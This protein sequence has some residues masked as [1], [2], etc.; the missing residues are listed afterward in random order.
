MLRPAYGLV[1]VAA[2][3]A[4]GPAKEPSAAPPR[5]AAEATGEPPPDY[6]P[7]GVLPE[8]T[9]Y[10]VYP[11]GERKELESALLTRRAAPRPGVLVFSKV[12]LDRFV[13]DVAEAVAQELHVPFDFA[14]T[15]RPAFFD[16]AVESVVVATRVLVDDHDIATATVLPPTE[17]PTTP[18]QRRMTR[19]E[20]AHAGARITVRPDG[21]ARLTELAERRPGYPLVVVYRGWAGGFAEA[22]TDDP[23]FEL[24]FSWLSEEA[25]ENA[26]RDF[27]ARVT[28][29]R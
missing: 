1:L 29:R 25:A 21:R 18:A 6:V 19:R 27:V 17:E 10:D 23:V 4:H 28:K 15:W 7:F 8:I 5:P 14:V 12:P 22:R 13:P 9:D 2:C 24:R 11:D 16:A 20:L 3:A 26:A